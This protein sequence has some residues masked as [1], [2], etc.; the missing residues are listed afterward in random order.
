MRN[1][2]AGTKTTI[3]SDGLVGVASDGAFQPLLLTEADA[4]LALAISPRTLWALEAS[5]QIKAVRIGRSI[6]APRV[7]AIR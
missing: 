3:T 1:D 2:T 5:G 6:R 7:G 4:A